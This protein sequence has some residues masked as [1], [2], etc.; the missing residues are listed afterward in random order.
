MNHVAQAANEASLTAEK[1]KDAA[2]KELEALQRVL[3]SKRART[4]DAADEETDGPEAAEDDLL[5]SDWRREATR[6]RPYCELHAASHEPPWL[7]QRGPR[8]IFTPCQRGCVF[9]GIRGRKR[10]VRSSAV[11]HAML[12]AAPREGARSIADLGRTLMD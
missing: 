3:D 5:L 6:V 12:T 7:Q 11:V 8:T 1:E 9:C 10:T 4:G 2:E